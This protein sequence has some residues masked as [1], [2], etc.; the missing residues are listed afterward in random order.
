MAIDGPV[1]SLFQQYQLLQQ[2]KLFDAAFYLKQN[3]DV[4]CAGLNPLLH[5]LEHGAAESRAPSADF[6]VAYYREQC[7]EAGITVTNPLVHYA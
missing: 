4:V 5:Y 1:S 6:D 2:S 7:Q 3:P